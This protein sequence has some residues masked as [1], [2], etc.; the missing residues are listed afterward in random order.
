[1]PAPAGIE[2]CGFGLLLLTGSG[3]L[4]LLGSLVFFILDH[5]FEAKRG[6]RRDDPVNKK[7][8]NIIFH[9]IRAS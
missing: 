3:L 6:D 2:K 8:P 7:S 5:N 4:L 9:D 1:M